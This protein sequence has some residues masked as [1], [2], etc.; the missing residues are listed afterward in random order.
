MNGRCLALRWLLYLCILSQARDRK[1]AVLHWWTTCIILTTNV[2]IYWS[3]LDSSLHRTPH[4]RPSISQIFK[5]LSDF[6]L[7]FGWI[8]KTSMNRKP[9]RFSCELWKSICFLLRLLSPSFVFSAQDWMCKA[10]VA[11]KKEGI[12]MIPGPLEINPA[13]CPKHCFGAPEAKLKNLALSHLSKGETILEQFQ[14]ESESS[15]HI[16]LWPSLSI[17]CSY[18]WKKCFCF[19]EVP[20]GGSTDFPRL[21]FSARAVPKWKI[22]LS[23]S[24]NIF[25][26]LRLESEAH[27]AEITA[28]TQLAS[29]PPIQSFVYF[30]FFLLVFGAVCASSFPSILDLSHSGLIL[31]PKSI[32]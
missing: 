26:I 32:A 25:E 8:L 2:S 21:I 30:G 24:A 16:P 29:S 19:A 20:R 7:F 18:F 22:T 11:L 15:K 5:V 10:W 9:G 12:M 14:L 27:Y 31:S 3:L 1:G 28:S 17:S 4:K 23:D 6:K 13:W